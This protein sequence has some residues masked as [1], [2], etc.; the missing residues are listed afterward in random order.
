MDMTPATLALAGLAAGLALVLAGRRRGGRPRRA[1]QAAGA[2]GGALCAAALAGLPF[3]A[4]T[5]QLASGPSGLPAAWP[6]AGYAEGVAGGGGDAYSGGFE[7]GLYHGQGTPAYPS[8]HTQQ[9]LWQDDELL[10]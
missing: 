5:G 10:P 8:G 3:L 4:A 2:L 7:H 1:P 9:G 6:H